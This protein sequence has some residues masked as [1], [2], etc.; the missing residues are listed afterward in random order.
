MQFFIAMGLVAT[1]GVLL[2]LV[3]AL[4]IT[5]LLLARRAPAE[6]DYVAA[7]LWNV[8]WL[9]Q[10]LAVGTLA[11]RFILLP[12]LDMSHLGE[13]GFTVRALYRLYGLAKVA[14]FALLAA[15]A[16]RWRQP[17]H[18]RGWMRAIVAV[19]LLQAAVVLVLG[20]EL[21][22]MVVRNARFAAPAELLAAWMLFLSP[23][24]RENPG[25]RMTAWA[26]VAV[27]V[28]ALIDAEA[29]WNPLTAYE[30]M[31]HLRQLFHKQTWIVH[32]N[33]YID[34]ALQALLAGGM[35]RMLAGRGGARAGPDA[36]PAAGARPPL[37]A[38]GSAVRGA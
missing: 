33:S 4:G 26:F 13:E 30:R 5:S 18:A 25:V 3:V 37:P 8:A 21:N 1:L 32:Y 34:T 20:D 12:N 9:F 27:A 29:F 17:R 16:V 22:P 31:T 36:R 11:L 24:G 15:G 7:G 10:A 28:V 35:L 38:H 19:S 6:G 23:G 2:Q 14:F